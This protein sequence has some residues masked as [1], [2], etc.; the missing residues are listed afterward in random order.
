MQTGYKFYLK[1]R[2]EECFRIWF[3]TWDIVKGIINENQIKSINAFDET[4]KLTQYLSNWAMDFQE[5]LQ[6]I[7]RKMFHMA[8]ACPIV[9]L[10]LV[11]VIKKLEEMILALV[12][13]GRNIRS[14]V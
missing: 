12:E 8:L 10:N 4:Y 13:V 5:V 2:T 14:A 11:K 9:A 1:N 7:F 6:V 3:E